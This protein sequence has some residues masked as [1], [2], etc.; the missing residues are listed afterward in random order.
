MRTLAFTMWQNDLVGLD[1]WLNYY[2][3]HFTDVF[4]LCF[5]TNPKYYPE[6]EKRKVGY[7]ILEGESWDD[8]QRANSM[9]RETQQEFLKEYVL[10]L[11]R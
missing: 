8:P 4:I 5:S 11:G 3:K 6:L 9:L 1:L 10:W 7:R 2:K